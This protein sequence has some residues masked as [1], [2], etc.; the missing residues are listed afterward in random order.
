MLHLLLLIFLLHF[1]LRLLGFLPSSFAAL[2]RGPGRALEVVSIFKQNAVNIGL[3]LWRAV[4]GARQAE[5]LARRSYLSSST[6][7]VDT[8]YLENKSRG[9]G[10]H[11]LRFI[12]SLLD[13]TI[14]LLDVRAQ[15]SAGLSERYQKYDAVESMCWE[16]VRLEVHIE[17]FWKRD[18]GDLTRID[19]SSEQDQKRCRVA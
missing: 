4:I 5:G 12:R 2:P 17:D 6:S 19:R 1:F 14:Q 18:W 3:R 10:L 9:R 11:F 15:Y 7:H 8:D 13:V 16:W